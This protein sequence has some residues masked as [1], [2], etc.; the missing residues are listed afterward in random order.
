MKEHL[1]DT[2]LE[3][4]EISLEAQLQALRQLRSSLPDTRKAT[5]VVKPSKKLGMSQIDMAS[6]ILRS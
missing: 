1:R 6:D 5:A 2:L 4:I 3:V